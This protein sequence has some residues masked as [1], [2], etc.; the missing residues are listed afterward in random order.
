MTSNTPFGDQPGQPSA[1]GPG[2]A[3]GYPPPDHIQS[4]YT[5]PD[6]IQSG[7]GGSSVW[8][9]GGGETIESSSAAPGGSRRAFIPWVIGLAVVL[10][11]GTGAVA[12]RAALGEDAGGPADALPGS[13]L[14]FARVDVDPSADQ[15]VQ[16]LR[17]ANRFPG[18]ADAT[19]LTDPEMDL[20]LSLFD[21]IR[22]HSPA[23]DIDFGRDVEPWLGSSFGV[24]MFAPADGETVPGVALAVEVTDQSAAEE[25]LAKLL[26][27]GSG[28]GAAAYSF[29]G[30]YAL[31]ATTQE[32]A[33]GYAADAAESPLSAN[34][35]FQADMA[36]LGDEGVASAWVSADAYDALSE[37][38][39]GLGG[40]AGGMVPG[41][42]AGLGAGLGVSGGAPAL[43]TGSMAYALRFEERYVEVAMVGSGGELPAASSDSESPIAQLPEST[44]FAA[45]VADGGAYVQQS[46][47]QMAAAAEQ[48]GMN[49]ERE[50]RRFEKETGLTVPDDF[51]TLLGEHF[52]FAVDSDLGG[53]DTP[54]E[55]RVGALLD[56]DA[57][58]AQTIIDKIV[59]A[60]GGG[61]ELASV[62]SDGLLA[63]GPNEAYATELAG[64]SL[65]ESSSFDLAVAY[66]ADSDMAF[67]LNVDELETLD[68][69]ASEADAEV[70]ENIATLQ[71]VGFSMEL[72][73]DGDSRGSLRVTVDE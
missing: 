32:L 19:G 7:P 58:A 30:S 46:L 37:A 23:A 57:A 6:E 10:V 26:A 28:E 68:Q 22:E 35:Q 29:S 38:A 33:D 52:T 4:G 20:R 72:T 27:L 41:L 55:L 3:P 8:S 21:A 17:L 9:P 61:I 24:A 15:K 47:D 51:V 5:R 39:V 59:A 49:F 48:T 65:G 18:F 36:S 63:V 12:V 14:V 67:Y 44:L 50:L 73:G 53:L 62:E 42:G 56:T 43:Q 70:L 64:G 16:A 31:F 66:G 25:G 2:Q 71:A 1:G 54:T 40:M 13:A 45:S 60:A 69:F 11:L 34:E